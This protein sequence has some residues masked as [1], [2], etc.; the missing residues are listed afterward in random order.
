MLYVVGTPIGNLQ[1]MTFRAVEILQSVDLIAAED[2]RHTGKL[3]HHFQIKTPQVSYHEHNH[4]QRLPELLNRLGQG[5][6]IALVT[7]AGMPAISDPGYKLVKAVIEEGISVVPIPGA[8]AGITALSAAGLPTDRFVFEGFLPTKGQSRKKRLDSLKEEPRTLIL[9]EGPHRVLNTLRD[10]ANC[11][12]ENRRIVLARELTKLHEEFWRGTIGDAIA[13]FTH[14]EPKGEF[15]LIIGGASQQKPMLSKAELEAQ[16]TEIMAQ[17]V[18]RSQAS[19]QLAK[20]TQLPRREL[21]QLAL[22][23]PSSVFPVK[24]QD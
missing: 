17:G 18:S 7:D 10:L 3:L 23:I 22:T 6:T 16:L 14:L 11:L 8:T 15:T 24:D 1:D 20:L 4:D 21:Y 5:N 2:T 13:H 9:Y 12:G 19:R